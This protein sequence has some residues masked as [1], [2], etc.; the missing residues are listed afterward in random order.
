MTKIGDKAFY[1]CKNLRYILV[2]TNKLTAQNVGN[3]AFG[4]GAAKLR[5]KTDKNK[6]KLYA[7][8]FMSRGMSNKALFIIDPVKLVI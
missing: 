6:W 8:I 7:Q 2:K 1:Q 4:R 5:V 3:N